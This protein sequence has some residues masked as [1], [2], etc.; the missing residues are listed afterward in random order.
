MYRSYAEYCR[1]EVDRAGFSVGIRYLDRQPLSLTLSRAFQEGIRFIIII[2]KDNEQSNTVSFK[3]VSESQSGSCPL[4]ASS[5]VP[6]APAEKRQSVVMPLRRAINAMLDMERPQ[7]SPPRRRRYERYP[8]PREASYAPTLARSP[9]RR[10]AYAPPDARL[11]PSGPP[12]P[13]YHGYEPQAPAVY[14]SR[15]RYPPARRGAVSSPPG[16][17]SG[18][19]VVPEVQ[20]ISNLLSY[21]DSQTPPPAPGAG[22]GAYEPHHHQPAASPYASSSY[23]KDDG[24]GMSPLP[25]L[26]HSYRS[27]PPPHRRTEPYDAVYSRR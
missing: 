3:I 19:D 24:H 15:S 25:P 22:Y 16:R 27:L 23:Y 9:P 13:R 2:G 20:A 7:L 5:V 14:E 12:P 10:L 8:M 6:N 26:P 18:A 21:F 17:R 11:P 1:S 4:A